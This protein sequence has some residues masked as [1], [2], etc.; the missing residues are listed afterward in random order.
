VSST[1]ALAAAVSLAPTVTAVSADI[2]VAAPTATLIASLPAIVVSQPTGQ[3]AVN[4]PATVVVS[5]MLAARV[6]TT[7]PLES[8]AQLLSL[9]ELGASIPMST[10][11]VASQRP[12][13]IADDNTGPTLPSGGRDVANASGMVTVSESLAITPLAT[14]AECHLNGV[15]SIDAALAGYVHEA[16]DAVFADGDIAAGRVDDALLNLLADEVCDRN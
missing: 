2:P 4:V 16:A 12:D 15:S 5:A 8:V 9:T 7:N 13:Q 11:I 1:D 6:A 14:G 3:A 10:Q